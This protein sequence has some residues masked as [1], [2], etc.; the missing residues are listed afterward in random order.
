MVT[1]DLT[2][3]RGAPS[4]L[5]GA[6]LLVAGLT[7][8]GVVLGAI[9]PGLAG[10]THPHPTLIGTPG[11]AASIFTNNL[12]VIAAPFALWALG[13]GSSRVARAIGD[14]LVFGL[15]AVNTLNVG[16][17]L[18]RWG[19][20]LVPY[21]SQLPLEWSALAIALFAWLTGRE[22][23]TSRRRMAMLAATVIAL[24]ATAAILETWCT[25]HVESERTHGQTPARSH[26]SGTA[27]SSHPDFA[28]TQAL[29][30]QGRL[31]LPSPH[32][33]SVPLGL[34]SSLTGLT[35]TTDP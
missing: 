11:E 29:P 27:V 21:V 12:R 1:T 4:P 16:V 20:Q 25:P 10:S 18:G 22:Q 19:T 32:K 3:Q 17:E 14:V 2:S 28:S 23:R 9:D 7:G 35:S 33:R 34:W 13:F 15:A 8:A 30:L 31:R 26:L 24:L 6:T 5:L